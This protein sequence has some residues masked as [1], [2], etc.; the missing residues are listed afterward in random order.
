MVKRTGAVPGQDQEHRRASHR[1][2]VEWQQNNKFNDL[3]QRERRIDCAGGWCAETTCW[4]TGLGIN[5][6]RSK[7]KLFLTLI[8]QDRVE[9]VHQCLIHEECLEQGCNYS[10]AFTQHQ[11]CAVHPC[12][13]ALEDCQESYLWQIC[14]EKEQEIDEARQE[15]DG[16]E[17]GL[18]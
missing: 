8:Y 13:G 4:V 11:K 1:N 6:P 2:E 12:A 15:D 18:E 14:E 7:H 16:K 17:A 5:D 9:Y 10:G 3:A